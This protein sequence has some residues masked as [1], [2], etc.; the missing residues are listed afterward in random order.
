MS[1]K[2]AV[3]LWALMLLVSLTSA[4]I[5]RYDAVPGD[6]NYNR[7]SM[8]TI[9]I[10]QGEGDDSDEDERTLTQALDDWLCD[11]GSKYLLL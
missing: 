3:A 7:V 2:R 11:G 1:A 6:N 10:E 8:H 9:N 5:C 4:Q